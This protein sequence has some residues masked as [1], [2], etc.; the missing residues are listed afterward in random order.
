V[1]KMLLPR[2]RSSC[3]GVWLHVSA[4]FFLTVITAT[5]A[6]LSSSGGDKN[7]QNEL[8]RRNGSRGEK[9]SYRGR[10]A[11]LEAL[12]EYADEV[13]AAYTLYNFINTQTNIP[14]YVSSVIDDRIRGNTGYRSRQ[15]FWSK[16]RNR[17]RGDE[18]AAKRRR[19]RRQAGDDIPIRQGGD[20]REAETHP[21]WFPLQFSNTDLF[22]GVFGLTTQQ[23][24]SEATLKVVE[25]IGFIGVNSL[26]PQL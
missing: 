5:G 19:R 20:E 17:R 23:A 18:V 26:F 6:G 24:I 7:R 4:I 14:K 22:L 2:F 25:W 21:G 15:P 10:Q 3:G 8:Q 9:S 16:K 13:E 11:I 12:E 1:V